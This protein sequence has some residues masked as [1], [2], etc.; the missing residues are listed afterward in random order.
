MSDVNVLS[1]T[2]KIIVNP[3]SHA[4][5]IVNAGPQGPAG[6]GGGL[7]ENQAIDAVGEATVGDN[8]IEADYDEGTHQLTI[9]DIPDRI[10]HDWDVDGWTPFGEVLINDDIPLGNDGDQTL[11]VVSGR[12]RITNS[13]TQGNL[14]K[15]YPRDDTIW[16][17][18]EITTLCYGGDVFNDGGTNPAR[19]QGGHFHR[20]YI[21]VDGFW[22]AIVITNNIF[23][24]DVNVINAN[25][26]NHDPTEADGQD[27]LDL[28]SN[29]GAKTYSN[30]HLRRDLRIIAV[31]RVNFGGTFN[32]YYVVP[33][34]LHGIEIGTSVVVDA[35][36]DATFDIATA[37]PVLNAARGFLQLQDAEAGANVGYKVETGTIIPTT[38][39]ARR[40]WPY[41][42]KSRLIGS[43]LSVKV[44][45]Q[46]DPEPDWSNPNAVNNYD[47]AGAQN[48]SPGARY[49]DEPG[50][51]GLIGA[52][53]RNT[54]YFEYGHFSAR[55]L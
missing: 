41:W 55:K 25:V 37:Q 16:M 29:G 36:L 9:R 27:Q 6:P 32:E 30:N 3:T 42:F 47:F 44:W 35:Q 26:W 31:S 52:H 45:R 11:S 23:L 12:G 40:W 49:P 8:N 39:G 21:D 19:P 24:T 13:N 22:R 28:G 10:I 54:R 1:R 14:R 48:P 18:S 33:D 53:I 50:H 4:V 46:L 51:C 34:N 38:E 17:D 2:Q 5:S 43:K 15:A 7:T 20:G